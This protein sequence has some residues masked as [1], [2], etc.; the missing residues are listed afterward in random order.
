[1]KPYIDGTWIYD[2]ETY[3]NI[4]SFGAV[5][6]NGNKYRVYEVSDRKNETQQLLEFFRNLIKHEHRLVGFNN[7]GFDYP[8]IHHIINQ[9]KTAKKFGIEYL[10]DPDEIYNVAVSIISSMRE[11]KFGKTI[12]DKDVVIPQIDLFK[13]HHFD[14]KARSTSLKMLEF[15]MRS[16]NIED[17][18]FP[19]GTVLNDEQKDVLLHYNKHDVMETHK[20][21]LKSV[22]AI[23]FR[24][25]LTERYGFDCTNFNDTKIGKQYFINRMEM[26]VPGSCYKLT[27]KGREVN[28]TKRSFINVNDIIF[29]Y[30]RFGRKEFVEVM[31][32]F[33]Q[34]TITETK[35]VFTDIE[36]YRLGGLAEY[37]ELTIKRKKF[38]TK[39]TEE[40]CINFMTN[41]PLGWIEEEQLRAKEDLLDENGNPVMTYPLNKFGHPDT[42]KKPKK[43]KVNKKSYW[44]C[45]KVADTLNVVVNGF[46]FDFGTG[47]IHGSVES[48]I[49]KSDDEYM[50][51]D[52]DVASMYPNLAISNQVYPEH[53]GRKFCDIYKDVYEERKKYKKGSAENAVMKLALNGTYGESNNQFSPLYDPQFTMAITINGQLSLCM[54][55]EMLM[56]IEGC[57]IIQC[58]TDGVTVMIP[59]KHKDKYDQVCSEWQKVV[60]LELEFAEYKAMYVRDVNSY[61]AL[62]TD[63]KVKRKGAYEYENLG[64]HQ[65]QSSLVI[66]MAAEHELL[67]RGFIEDFVIGHK[68]KWD[69]LLRTKVPRN[70]KLV[71]VMDN[72]DEVQQQNIC[73]YY[74]SKTG[75]ELVKIMPPLEGK[76]D[77]GDRRL[78]LDKGWKVKTCNNIN[79][80]EWDI[81]YDYYIQEAK[82]LV[83]PL[84]GGTDEQF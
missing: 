37:S 20:F 47:G 78:S 44:G 9:A 68:N 10:I 35:G 3:P 81:N 53:L 63:G 82:K 17:L 74:I 59:R 26:I 69:F 80:F 43:V 15:N 54:L 27:R 48:Q 24:E 45:W 41:H 18:P 30:V 83:L 1:M 46:R 21:Y 11:E 33:R 38:K 67:G 23:R 56:G 84:T 66:P 75:G 50:I 62:Y 4:F 12:Q 77:D 79:D 19:V 7:I 72:G 32:W 65:D 76:E 61:L 58:N 13:I 8:V 51:I 36:E 25:Q 40:E 28:Q 49:V 71:M 52:A 31:D 34:Q 39:P 55:S 73:R 70:S 57:K 5:Y 29:P 6:A 64:W 42:T 14:N 16:E 22:G 60:K 2:I